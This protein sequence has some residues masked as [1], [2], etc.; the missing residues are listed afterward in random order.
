MDDLTPYGQERWLA[1]SKWR[2]GLKPD[3]DQ[4]EI[5]RCLDCV[6]WAVK[7]I[8]PQTYRCQKCG[9]GY[10]ETLVELWRTNGV[11]KKEKPFLTAADLVMLREMRI[12]L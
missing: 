1:G 10:H 3:N 6:E 11:Y 12:K 4:R 9:C 8:M 7:E 5:F 2:P